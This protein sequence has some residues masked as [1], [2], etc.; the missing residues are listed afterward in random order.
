MKRAAIRKT[1]TRRLPLTLLVGLFGCGADSATTSSGDDGAGCFRSA[2]VLLSESPIQQSGGV[3]PWHAG[4]FRL[5]A[6]EE[7]Q[8][9]ALLNPCTNE[10][11]E[12]ALGFDPASRVGEDIV[13]C[14]PETETLFVADAFGFPVQS[15]PVQA[16]DCWR[17]PLAGTQGAGVL[18][19]GHDG[20]AQW[21]D[22]AGPRSLALVDTSGR[23]ASITP[24]EATVS[25]VKNL[26]DEALLLI[27]DDGGSM[28]VVD[29]WTDQAS[30]V[31]SNVTRAVV[32]GGRVFYQR[33][34]TGPA[35]VYDVD[36]ERS[37]T[38]PT[39]EVDLGCAVDS[40]GQWYLGPAPEG[41]PC[42]RDRSEELIEVDSGRA[43]PIPEGYEVANRWDS[44][45]GPFT[46]SGPALAEWDPKGDGLRVLLDE[47]IEWAGGLYST[48]FAPGAVM[49]AYV[50]GED[51][52]HAVAVPRD[53]RAPWVL[54][55][56][57]AVRTI[58]LHDAHGEV[59]LTD[60]YELVRFDT[61]TQTYTTVDTHVVKTDAFP[62]G[63]ESLSHV[64][65]L[66]Y[67]RLDESPAQTPLDM[68]R[69]E[70]WWLPL[71][72]G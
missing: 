63:I 18:T 44:E 2:P 23:Q 37:W 9:D 40:E 28:H 22:E 36:A 24:G 10:M 57:R 67:E 42:S 31:A 70:I 66:V 4:T 48:E 30:V 19:V 26:Q 16:R 14:D 62:T 51:G 38:L 29:P 32:R 20:R 41:R 65:S 43:F 61:A 72:P 56:G 25:T 64:P 6:G 58:A 68:H 13:G 52:T 3:S 46:L 15:Q 5:H 34:E 60:A 71:D 47:P 17:Y 50:S 45:G 53:G 7:G 12:L 49:V 59:A 35:N 55:G 21:L 8:P 27:V 69:S 54:F 11:T 1:A 39:S 33:A